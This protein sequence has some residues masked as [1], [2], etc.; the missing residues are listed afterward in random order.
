MT[1]KSTGL[2]ELY[3]KHNRKLHKFIFNISMV[4]VL[5]IGLSIPSPV[6]QNAVA[7]EEEDDEENGFLVE[8][9]QVEG[10]IDIIEFLGDR[11]DMDEGELTG[12][13]LTQ[14]SVSADGRTLIVK[15]HSE[16]P[17]PVENLEGELIEADVDIITGL[18]APSEIGWLCLEDVEMELSSQEAGSISLPDATVETC[19]EGE[20]EGAGDVDGTNLEV[21]DLEIEDVDINNLNDLLDNVEEMVEDAQGMQ[22][23][24][25]EEDQVSAVEQG[26]NEAWELVGQPDDFSEAA[27]RVKNAHEELNENV[28][29]MGLT[30]ANADD[31]LKQISNQIEM[32]EQRIDEEEEEWME[33]LGIEPED[34]EA[35]L[36]ELDL[37]DENVDEE[38]LPDVGIREWRD[39]ISDLQERMSETSEAIEE[40]MQEHQGLTEEVEG[41]RTGAGELAE[42]VEESDEYAD[43]QRED[44]FQD[45]DVAEP[46]KTVEK[47]IDR[48]DDELEGNESREHTEELE[49]LT[50]E[51]TE[52]IEE[53]GMSIELAEEIGETTHEINENMEEALEESNE[54]MVQH[55]EEIEVIE[56]RLNELSEKVEVPEELA[57]EYEIN[58]LSEEEQ[59]EYRLDMQANVSEWE[60]QYAQLMEGIGGHDLQALL[61]EEQEDLQVLMDELQEYVEGMEDELSEEEFNALMEGL[62]LDEAIL[63]DDEEAIEEEEDEASEEDES[64]EGNE[65]DIQKQQEIAE[66]NEIE[67]Q[68]ENSDDSDNNGNEDSNEDTS[69]SSESTDA[70]AIDSA[71]EDESREEGEGT[72]ARP[73]T[74]ELSSSYGMRNG[75]MHNGIDIPEAGRSNVPIEAAEAGE[76]SYTGYMNGLGNTVMVTHQIDGETI[77]TLYAHL[78]SIDV[79]VGD[80]VNRAE[81]IGIMGNTGRSTGP[82]VHFEVHEGGWDGSGVNS[83]N[84]MPYLE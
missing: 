5:I 44:I 35:Y 67:R 41:F 75:R 43:D 19:F 57:A 7:E 63:E 69:G 84:P 15:I 27:D 9:D 80:T 71:S 25:Q 65:E 55:E 81:S 51:A 37:E 56:S 26:L 68:E 53:S 47:T 73:A 79:S 82:H 11:I 54:N 24:I 10:T 1:L 45:L 29:D 30:T 76:V 50:E 3:M 13:T 18:C 39:E 70:A 59:N 14:E 16:G 40:L 74:G 60:D 78:S 4:F 6:S 17:V 32:Y 58:E 42:T 34:F 20:C 33:E 52:E 21:D 28:T 62:D 46:G 83:V 22:Q 72:L 36:E 23:T 64:S 48:I 2:G 8:A 66:Q 77:T 31:I 49:E 12:L 61:Q 38:E